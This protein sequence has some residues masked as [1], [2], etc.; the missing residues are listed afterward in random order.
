MTTVTAS[1]PAYTLPS[2]SGASR[3]KAWLQH[4]RVVK[5]TPRALARF[6][7][8]PDEYILPESSALACKGIGNAVPPL[9]M[10]KIYRQ[11]YE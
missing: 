8:F 11:F 10:E 6:Q 2:T 7:S 1:Q 3:H 5:M 4:G 9:M